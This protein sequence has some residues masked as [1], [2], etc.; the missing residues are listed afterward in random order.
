MQD[1]NRGFTLIELII[2]IVVLGIL[3]ATV[4]PK[5]VNLGGDARKAVMQGVEGSMRSANAIIYAKA[6]AAGQLG[7][8]GSVTIGGTAVNTKYGYAATF[9]PDLAAAMDI[10]PAA[11]FTVAAGSIQHAKAG[12]PANCSVSYTAP[13]AADTSPAYTTDVSGC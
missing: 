5:F 11:D 6:A 13:A 2:V 12:T 4:L 7:V 3:A 1:R 8:A 9:S 10:S